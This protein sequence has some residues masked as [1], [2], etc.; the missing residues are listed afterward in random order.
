MKHL[1]ATTKWIIVIIVISV[2]QH[3]NG[4]TKPIQK[5]QPTP[6]N[7]KIT[8]IPKTIYLTS[9]FNRSQTKI[10]ISFN[11]HNPI[12][13]FNN[14]QKRAISLTKDEFETTAQFEQKLQIEIK[15]NNWKT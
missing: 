1:H 15:T 10:P 8:V 2:I 12:E 6:V 13:L 14:L 5:K 9:S 3:L 11:G 7:S 4:Q